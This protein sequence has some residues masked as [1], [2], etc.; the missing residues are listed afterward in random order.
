MEQ[1]QRRSERIQH[2]HRR[3]LSRPGQ[4][5]ECGEGTSDLTL[6]S[7]WIDEVYLADIYRGNAI[8]EGWEGIWI[9]GCGPARCRREDICELPMEEWGEPHWG[10]E[11]AY[12]S[13]ADENR[14]AVA[15]V[16]DEGPPF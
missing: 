2:P 8:D 12:A 1:Q 16:Y 9:V 3:P 14:T 15:D 7:Q 10:G 13:T 4:V 5:V 11:A 6:A